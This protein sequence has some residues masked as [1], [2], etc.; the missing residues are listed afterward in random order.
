M[1]FKGIRPALSL[2]REAGLFYVVF[3]QLRRK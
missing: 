1:P 2:G 3:D